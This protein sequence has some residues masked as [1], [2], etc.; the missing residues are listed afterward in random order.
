MRHP[1]VPVVMFHS[2]ADDRPDRPSPFILYAGS[3]EFESYLRYLRARRYTTVSL[4]DVHAWHLGERTLPARSVVLTFDDGYLDNWVVVGPLLR[5]YGFH[6]TLFLPTDFVQP[7]APPRPTLEDV[8]AGR[9]RPSELP[10]YGYVNRAELRAMVASGTFD[11][12][13]HG[14][15]HTWLPCS[16]EVVT[17]HRP[18]L[19]VRRHLRWMWWNRFPDRK[20]FWFEEIRHEH[21]PWGAPVFRSDLALAG[22]AFVPHPGL[23]PRLTRYVADHGGAELFRRPDWH[24]V[25]SR[26]AEAFRR[27]QGPTAM[28][29]TDDQF[30]ARLRHEIEGSRLTLEGMTGRPVRFLCWPNG[31]VCD[32]SFE[33]ALRQG[34]LATTIPSRMGRGGNRR[35]DPPSR[36]RRIGS[37]PYFQGTAVWPKMLSFAMQIERARGNRL[38]IPLVR[39][40]WLYR[41][42]FPVRRPVEP[43]I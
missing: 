27:E 39:T 36:I 1:S 13:S 23:E 5:K 28:P 24:A 19:S 29:E 25:L 42:L 6:A 30:A 34:Y 3:R 9:L 12:Q 16:D 18:G 17:F 15:T 35:E 32:E 33:A 26:E 38:M 37:T 43:S 8:W 4:D 21:V 31:G 14:R 11:V 20:P 7:E 40:I 22:R 41:R 10:L 2:V